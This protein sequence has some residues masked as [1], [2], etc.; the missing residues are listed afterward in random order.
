MAIR[1]LPPVEFLRECF[2]YAPDTGQ[3][4]WKHR[5]EHHFPSAAAA[6]G[7]NTQKA[8]AIAGE[9]PN[10]DGYIRLDFRRGD[11]R[12]RTRVH[13]VVWKMHHGDEPEMLDHKN[14]DPA[15]NRV[16]NLRPATPSENG[17]N[18]TGRLSAE[19][20][21]PK[22]VVAVGRGR[23]RALGYRNGERAYLGIHDTPAA[24]HAAYCAWAA[25]A[26]GEF[27]NPGP[28]KLTVFD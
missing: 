15:D 25:I 12:V 5:P 21:L 24:A 17:R 19:R 18:H 3:L 28:V 8:G 13:R 26:H 10:H 23:F 7:W 1:P 20:H 27:F 16:E 6:K 22:G 14:G 9:A 2:H 4:I 11:Q